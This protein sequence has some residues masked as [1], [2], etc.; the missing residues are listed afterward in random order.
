ML[1]TPT[2]SWKNRGS[3]W[4]VKNRAHSTLPSEVLLEKDVK[5][6][7]N[8]WIVECRRDYF[9]SFSQLPKAAFE[10]T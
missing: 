6:S 4:T 5:H 1:R 8:A 10:H 7:K 9:L 3:D 2:V